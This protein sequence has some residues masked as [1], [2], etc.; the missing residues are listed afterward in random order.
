MQQWIELNTKITNDGLAAM[1][2]IAEINKKTT[3]TLVAQ[4]KGM[5]EEYTTTTKGSM[6]KLAAVKDQKAFLALQ[7]EMFQNTITSALG[8]WKTI[9]ATATSGNDEYKALAEDTMNI[10][11]ENMEKVAASAKANM[12]QTAATVKDATEAVKK[13]ATPASS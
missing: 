13:A 11:K 3:E 2:Q 4:Q 7:S 10:A 9:V 1:K 8:N 5:L 12:E 6:E